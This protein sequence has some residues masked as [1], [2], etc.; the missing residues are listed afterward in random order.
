MIGSICGGGAAAAQTVNSCDK[1][2]K[3]DKTSILG[4]KFSDFS[5]IYFTGLAVLGL[6]LPATAYIVK[7]F[8]LVSVIA[9]GYSV[10]VQAF[11]EKHFA[12]FV[13]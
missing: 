4:L 9:I 5:L 12:G 3:Q 1:I 11:V 7:G 8:T 13:F 2:I 6:F 10:Y